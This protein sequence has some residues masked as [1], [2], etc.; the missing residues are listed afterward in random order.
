MRRI[1]RIP[2]F[3]MWAVNAAVVTAMV[4]VGVGGWFMLF[5][6]AHQRAAFSLSSQ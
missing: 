1:T 2:T 3:A 6:A 5:S 4:A